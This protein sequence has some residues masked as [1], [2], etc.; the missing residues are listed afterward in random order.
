[1]TSKKTNS[2]KQK[3][4]QSLFVKGMLQ[5]EIA[6]ILGVSEQTISKWRQK[7]NWDKIAEQ[8]NV[9]RAS[10]LKD[11]FIQLN[12]VN[13][14]IADNKNIPTKS[15]SDTKAQLLREIENFSEQPIY[16]YID[17]FEEFIA[18]LS[19]TE[20]KQLKLFSELSWKF[21]EEKQNLK[22]N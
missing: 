2:D 4:A 15:Q 5:K 9:T 11:S 1:M 21:I 20:P 6:D 14:E 7:F 19:K 12:A 13:K 22:T 8:N 16:K 17:I 3:H 10:L 18:W